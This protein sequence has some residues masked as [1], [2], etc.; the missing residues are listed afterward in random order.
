[1]IILDL[2]V[3]KLNVF[4]N[5]FTEKAKFKIILILAIFNIQNFLNK[6]NP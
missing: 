5:I 3:F 6:K 2:T 4:L 1:M